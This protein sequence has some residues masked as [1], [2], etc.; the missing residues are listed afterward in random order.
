[1]TMKKNIVAFFILFLQ[2]H[3]VQ[4]Q[5]TLNQ[6]V[7]GAVITFEEQMRDMG[8]MIYGDSLDYTFKFTN[9]GDKDLVIQNVVTT[10]SCTSRK[11]TEGPIAPGKSGEVK[12]HFDS[13]KQEKIGRQNKVITILSNATNNPERVI[14][15]FN[16]LE[17]GK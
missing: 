3:L 8:D 6:K 10:C 11:Y 17:K 13:S 1:M 14:L 16:I 7:N 12:V 5:D 4:A 15:N 9:T 2:I